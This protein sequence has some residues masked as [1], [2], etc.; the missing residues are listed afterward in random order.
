M[1]Q[2]A[3][4]PQALLGWMGALADATRLRLLRLLEQQELGVAELCDVVQLPQSNVSR[5]LKVLGDEGWVRSRRKGTVHLYRAAVADGDPAARKLW[6]VAREQTENWP[7]VR[8]DQLR[9]TRKLAEK[10]QTSEAFF[11]GAAG[12]WDKLR[13]EF[14][15]KAFAHHATF[16]LLPD[17][18]VVADL[19]CGT[20]SIA[21]QVAPWVRSVIGVDSSA[22]MLKAAG[23]RTAATAN[24]ELRRG[25]LTAVPI[26]SA[27]CDA[28][29]LVLVLSYVAN[30]KSV[31]SEMASIL[32]PG[33]RSVVVDLLP[34]DREDFRLRMGQQV[35]GFEMLQVK[36]MMEAVGMNVNRTMELAP[37]ADV[38]GP[39]LFLAS[40]ART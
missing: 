29:F 37:D 23:R 25:E 40:G 36:A 35:L 3:G 10:R 19:G 28:A 12:Q 30:A 4:Q 15:G 1:V 13:D 31:L 11:A 20:G 33:G 16:A 22:A 38:K 18:A 5:H 24:V 27:T 39:G 26:E 2:T 17:D 21:A 9:L 6:M 7:A 14:Y 32:K 34:H 8:Q